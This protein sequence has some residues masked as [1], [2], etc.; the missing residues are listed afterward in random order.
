MQ[1]ASIKIQKTFIDYFSAARRPYEIIDM[2]A[3]S[4]FLPFLENGIPSG[5]FTGNTEN[6]VLIESSFVHGIYPSL[7]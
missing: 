7:T 3:G 1:N 2:K 4:D 6:H 5:K